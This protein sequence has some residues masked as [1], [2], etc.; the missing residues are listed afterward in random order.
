[1]LGT[2]DTWSWSQ[3]SQLDSEPAYCIVDCSI[4]K[5]LALFSKD[6]RTEDENN[7]LVQISVPLNFTK[8]KGLNHKPNNAEELNDQWKF[9]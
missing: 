4:S 1:M 3:L 2:S 8:S 6:K 9:P 5:C 7:R